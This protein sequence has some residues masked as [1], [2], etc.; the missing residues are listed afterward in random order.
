MDESRKAH[1]LYDQAIH[2][3]AVQVVCILKRSYKFTVLE[4]RIECYIYFDTSEMRIFYGF[5]QL[6]VSEVVCEDPCVES[7]ASQ[8]YGIRAVIYSRY[9]MRLTS[10]RRKKFRHFHCIS[11]LSLFDICSFLTAI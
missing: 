8:I 10:D 7:N 2:A 6:L 9:E 1:V 11:P 3:Y 5:R 4:Q